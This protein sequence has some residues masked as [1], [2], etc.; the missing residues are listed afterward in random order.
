MQQ[1]YDQYVEQS[2]TDFEKNSLENKYE[3]YRMLVKEYRDGIL[4][5]QLMDEKVWSKAIEDT[6]GLKKYFADN[7]AKYQWDQRVQGTVVSAAT[8]A[9]LARV[10]KEMKTGRYPVTKDV[11]KPCAYRPGTASLAKTGVMALDEIGKRMVQD[12]LTPVTLDGPREEGRKSQPG[13]RPRRL[14]HART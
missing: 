11:P 6:V 8:P 14:R 10:Q 12:T 1:L 5:F 7:Q 3:D 2:L 4:L 9:L 13:Q